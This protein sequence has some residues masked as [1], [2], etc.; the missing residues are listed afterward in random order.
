MRVTVH[1]RAASASA[2]ACIN[3]S[4]APL[5]E[6]KDMSHSAIDVGSFSFGKAGWGIRGF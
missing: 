2:K 1:P 6:S 5:V 3:R 4:S